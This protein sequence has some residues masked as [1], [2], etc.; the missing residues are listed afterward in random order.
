LQDFVQ[1][2]PFEAFRD[3]ESF[4]STLAHETVH[5]ADLRIMPRRCS[6]PR[7]GVQIR[8]DLSA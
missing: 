2:P 6:F 7:A 1:M 8:R 3:A 4:Y 5:Y